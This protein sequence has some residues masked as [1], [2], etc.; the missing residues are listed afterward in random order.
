MKYLKV[1]L[2]AVLLL[3]CVT[4]CWT[5]V[6][7]VGYWPKVPVPE[8]PQIELVDIKDKVSGPILI[9]IKEHA[10]YE[11]QLRAVLEKYNEKADRH[12]KDMVKLLREN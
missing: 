8:K 10:V 11:A 5:K 6:V 9:I 4:G 1:G 3:V 7:Y 2:L 12:N